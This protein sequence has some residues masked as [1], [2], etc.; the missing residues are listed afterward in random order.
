MH[1]G[2]S[3]TLLPNSIP[4]V[5]QMVIYLYMNAV[6]NP[7]HGYFVTREA[8]VVV[9]CASSDALCY[10]SLEQRGLTGTVP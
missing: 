4:R 1:D 10:H 9:V 8:V 5:G 3:L 2:S 7:F 6:A